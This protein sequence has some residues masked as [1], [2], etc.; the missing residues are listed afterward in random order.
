MK[1]KLLMIFLLAMV[2][3]MSIMIIKDHDGPYQSQVI[4]VVATI[5]VHWETDLKIHDPFAEQNN[6]EMIFRAEIT[7]EPSEDL[8]ISKRVGLTDDA[9]LVFKI[10]T[11]NPVDVQIVLLSGAS[12][13]T[14]DTFL[15]PTGS[16]NKFVCEIRMRSESAGLFGATLESVNLQS[17]RGNFQNRVA[18]LDGNWTSPKIPLISKSDSW[19]SLE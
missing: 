5:D 8:Y 12:Q 13:S 7:I 16:T 1:T 4:P 6:T 9:G 3:V 17:R 10:Q 14:D 2:A 18:L 15:L 11:E 19:L